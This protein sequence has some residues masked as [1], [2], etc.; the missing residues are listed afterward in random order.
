MDYAL[1]YESSSPIMTPSSVFPRSAKGINKLAVACRW[2]FLLT[3]QIYIKDLMM[4]TS[5]FGQFLQ[6][7]CCLRFLEKIPHNKNY[8][9]AT[10]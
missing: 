9:I 4:I 7:C 10:S 2:G 5:R 6:N 1:N 8:K 3:L